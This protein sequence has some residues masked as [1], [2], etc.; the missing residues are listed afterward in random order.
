MFE[1]WILSP[2]G[3]KKDPK[4]ATLVVRQVEKI[5]MMI[6]TETPES[7][8]N[9]KLIRDKF[10]PESRVSHKA[11]TTISYLHRYANSTPSP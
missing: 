5:L 3:G 7:L 11:T 6:G 1:K 10:Y 9:K 4:P 8:F 2:D